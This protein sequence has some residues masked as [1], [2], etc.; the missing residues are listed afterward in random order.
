MEDQVPTFSPLE[1]SNIFEKGHKLSNTADNKK[2]EKIE[3]KII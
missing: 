2:I 1:L 3:K